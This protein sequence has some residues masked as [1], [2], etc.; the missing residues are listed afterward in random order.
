MAAICITSACATAVALVY[1]SSAGYVNGQDSAHEQSASKRTAGPSPAHWQDSSRQPLQS[2]P[3]HDNVACLMSDY[4]L[5]HQ[6]SG[7]MPRQQP[8]A[9]SS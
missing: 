5:Q 3:D 1:V 9:S 7:E 8:L 4:P 2:R 6:G